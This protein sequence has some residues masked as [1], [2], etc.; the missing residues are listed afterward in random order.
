MSNT[1]GQLKVAVAGF[2]Q[3]D[4]STFV[5]TVNA[6]TWDVLL[7]ACNNARLYAERLIDFE[8]AKVPIQIES[9]TL[10]TGG[11]L[12]NAKLLGTSTAVGVKKLLDV[13]LATGDGG[14]YP[15]KLQTKAYWNK[16][17]LRRIENLLP[18]DV[19]NSLRV[20][21]TPLSLT[22]IG[23][24]I[25]VAPPDASALPSASFTVYAEAVRWLSPYTSAGTETD[26]LLDY[27]FDWLQYRAIQELNFFVKEDERVQL[28][29]SLVNDAWRAIV[30]WNGEL[31]ASTADD[32]SSLD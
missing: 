32:E 14:T 3:R 10:T 27:C 24:T 18:T 12:A 4:P 22:Q 8:L 29:T 13:F 9:V 19:A 21:E 6:V 20:I 26:F 11:S 30:Q 15:I 7:Q 16:R 2:M 17:M 25:A 1:S 23:Q 5:R 31:V 28:S